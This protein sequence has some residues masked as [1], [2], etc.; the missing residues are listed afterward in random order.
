MTIPAS[1]VA[2]PPRNA[3]N[4]QMRTSLWRA[5][6]LLLLSSMRRPVGQTDDA[7]ASSGNADASNLD[8]ELRA[9]RHLLATIE[10]SHWAKADAEP[11]SSDS[12]RA[13]RRKLAAWYHLDRDSSRYPDAPSPNGDREE[14]YA[15]WHPDLELPYALD[16]EILAPMTDSTASARPD[17]IADPHSAWAYVRSHDASMSN[18]L[19]EDEQ[20]RDA[21]GS[22]SVASALQRLLRV[23]TANRQ[24]T[25]ATGDTAQHDIASSTED[26]PEHL[27]TAGIGEADPDVSLTHTTSLSRRNAVRSLPLTNSDASS[28]RSAR[29][30]LSLRRPRGSF[31]QASNLMPIRAAVQDDNDAVE[32]DVVETSMEIGTVPHSP[33]SMTT[34]GPFARPQVVGASDSS[35]LP[36]PDRPRAGRSGSFTFITTPAAVLR[37]GRRSESRSR[38]VPRSQSPA[39][40][41]PDDA[42]DVEVDILEERDSEAEEYIDLDLDLG[43]AVEDAF[44][45][46][47]VDFLRTESRR[48]A[49]RSSNGD[50]DEVDLVEA[51]PP[52]LRRRRGAG[53]EVDDGASNTDIRVFVSGSGASTPAEARQATFEAY[54]QRA[55]VLERRRRLERRG[56]TMRMVSRRQSARRWVFGSFA[57]RQTT[58]AGQERWR[59]YQCRGGR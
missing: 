21:L 11:P 26:A 48:N 55:R 28:I 30:S 6:N 46:D 34:T 33:D 1:A 14:T 37:S 51:S 12:I 32:E 8:A 16:D 9:H 15:R 53:D 39:A 50:D 36:P 59:R 7:R 42:D 13:W 17:P 54:A 18:D 38:G 49:R 22:S 5:R 57:G 40:A 41:S 44:D 27:R 20:V 31:G 45:F 4:S 29:S 47:L 24:A 10:E 52:S 25:A 58:Q 2:A 3:D 56:R 19:N 23:H 35:L 43:M